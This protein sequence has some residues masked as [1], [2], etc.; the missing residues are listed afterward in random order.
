MNSIVIKG[1]LTREPEMR[2]AAQTNVCVASVAVNRRFKRD[3]TDFFD[4]QAWGKTGETL[5]NYFTKGQEILVHGEM[6]CSHYTAND[7]TQRQSWRINA[8]VIEFCGSKADG[9]NDA[10][11]KKPDGQNKGNGGFYPVDEALD[12]EDLPF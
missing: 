2:M 11:E 4:I 6:Q 7:G 12:D 5:K 9:A 1:R 8:D 10:K 3:E